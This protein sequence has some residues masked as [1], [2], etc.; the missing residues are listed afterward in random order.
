[1]PTINRASPKRPWQPERKAQGRRIRQNAAF[2]QGKH[3]KIARKMALDRD[4]GLCVKC[5]EFGFYVEAKVVDH[6]TPINEGGAEYELSNLQS[7]CDSCHNSKS[8]KEAHKKK[9]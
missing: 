5:L 8:G 7:L 2:Y 9:D 6:K 4:E 1:M 3:W